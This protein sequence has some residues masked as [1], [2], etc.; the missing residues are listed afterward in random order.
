MALNMTPTKK[1]II[2]TMKKA[3]RSHDEICAALPDCPNISDHQ[4]N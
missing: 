4:I 3:G 2:C 1:A